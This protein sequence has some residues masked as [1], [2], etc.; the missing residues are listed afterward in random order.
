[1]K[2]P[3]L[4]I[5]K[6]NRDLTKWVTFWDL[7][8]SA[9]HSN[10]TLLNIDKFSYLH[11]F[12]DSMVSDAIAS[13]T[14]TSANYEE[15]IAILRRRFSNEQLIVS[16][17]M[18]ALLILQTVT[19]YYDLK[20][21]RHLYDSVESHVRGL[22]ALGIDAVPCCQL[23]SLILMNELPTKMHLIISCELSGGKWNVEE[24]MRIINHEIEVRE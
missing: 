19:S 1:M 7:F 8:K 5:K 20:G 24:I 22:R 18:D 16:K 10:P 9:I 17:H 12:L 13:L 3:K 11:S 21:L 2:L 14:L 6:F 23:L 4:T 15:A